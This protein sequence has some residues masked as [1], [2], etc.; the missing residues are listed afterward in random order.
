[1][2]SWRC[3]IMHLAHAAAFMS[4]LRGHFVLHRLHMT[5]NHRPYISKGTI[6]VCIFVNSA[7]LAVVA[8]L[9]SLRPLHL[10][11]MKLR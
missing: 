11:P 5:A 6:C 2:V 8:A 4:N 1:V 10:N 7:I 9:F 3:T